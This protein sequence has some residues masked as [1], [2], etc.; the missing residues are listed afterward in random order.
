LGP[1]E[2]FWRGKGCDHCHGTG[3]SGRQAIYE[4]LVMDKQLAE[5][6]DVG[7]SADVYRDSALASRMFSLPSNGI[8]LART[9]AVSL[10]EIY[11]ACM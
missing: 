5:R 3:F 9:G 6:V 2:V 4:L 10:A 1:E 8:K 7:V 11:R